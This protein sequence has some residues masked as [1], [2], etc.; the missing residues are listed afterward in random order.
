MEFRHISVML[1][2]AT[3]ALN[4]KKDGI[5]V[6][7]TMG[8]GGH[9]EEILSNLSE[10]GLLIGIDRD[11][12]ALDASKKRLAKFNNVRYVHD[13][14]HN[15]K[16]ILADMGI[17]GIDGMLVDLGVSSYQLDNGERGFSY[18]EDAPLDMRMN[19]DDKLS[20]YEVVNTYSEENLAKIF[21]EYGEEK[22]S[23]KIARLIALRREDK[24]IETTLDLVSIIDK[25]IP[26]R[27]RV[28]GSHPAKR[29]FQAIRIE[30]NA[31][32]DPLKDALEDMFECLNPGGRLS[33]ITFHSLE[34]R[35][36]KTKFRSLAAGCTCPPDF[37][38]CVCGK[39]PRAKLI[40]RKPILPSAAEC[41]NNKRSRSAKLRVTEKI[42]K[43]T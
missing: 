20:A 12:Q 19:R 31:E 21:F 25:A 9:S 38:M 32:L 34:D 41:E 11:I 1:H 14:F 24:P 4:I 29:V 17:G 30:V 23:K 5:Y 43:G 18:M 3:E 16:R 42:E 36:V 7:G 13:N 26:E 10:N 8:G 37:P 15:I 28:K 22:F 33:V 2:E 40:T 35:I 6:D 39:K 27:F